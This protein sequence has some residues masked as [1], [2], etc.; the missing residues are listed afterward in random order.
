[1]ARGGHRAH[2]EGAAHSFASPADEALALPLAG[3]PST[4]IPWSRPYARDSRDWASGLGPSFSD[5]WN[6]A[7]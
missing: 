1:V 3:L 6:E 4:S 2:E 7:V 5:S